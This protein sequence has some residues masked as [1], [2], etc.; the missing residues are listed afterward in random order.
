M[1]QSIFHIV[2]CRSVGKK[3]EVVETLRSLAVQDGHVELPF[4]VRYHTARFLVDQ[5]IIDAINNYDVSLENTGTE[6]VRSSLRAI[7]DVVESESVISN[8]N[9]NCSDSFDANMASVACCH[10][11]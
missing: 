6:H 5:T 3:G 11:V 4:D 1:H 2:G 10:R 8:G 7:V 9:Y